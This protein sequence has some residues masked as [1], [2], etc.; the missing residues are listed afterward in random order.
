MKIGE[1]I[2]D[3]RTRMDISQRQFAR[4]CDL[5][6]SYISFLE[7]D[8][9]P[10]TGKPLVPTLEQYK[11][12]ATGMDMSLQQLFEMLDQDAPVSMEFSHSDDSVLPSDIPR[13]SEARILAKGIDKLPQEQREQALSVIR[14]MFVKYADF[15]EKENDNDDA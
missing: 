3:Y 8:V 5:S 4:R 7:K 12:L 9:N 6:N 2:L 13:T 10:Q 14:A 15:F 11:K 1:I